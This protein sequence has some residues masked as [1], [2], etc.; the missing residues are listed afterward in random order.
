MKTSKKI[1]PA[2]AKDLLRYTELYLK[3]AQAVGD[4]NSGVLRNRCD[5]SSEMREIISRTRMKH[6]EILDMSLEVLMQEDG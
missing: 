4:K 2:L 6:Q 3:F 1:D 5:A